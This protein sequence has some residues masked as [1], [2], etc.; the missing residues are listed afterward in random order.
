[1]RSEVKQNTGTDRWGN[2]SSAEYRLDSFDS[3]EELCD[4]THAEYGYGYNSSFYDDVNLDQAKKL[5]RDGWPE[6]LQ[7]LE[8]FRGKLENVVSHSIMRQEMFY[9]VTGLDWDIGAVMTGEPECWYDY[10]P[11]EES[12]IVRMAYNVTVSGGMG[13]EQ[14]QLRGA[15]IASLVDL[16]EANG[17]RVELDIYATLN[18]DNRAYYTFFVP[19]KQAGQQLDLDRLA[20]VFMHAGMSRKLMFSYAK[21][22][23]GGEAIGIGWGIAPD[24]TDYDLDISGGHI[25]LPEYSNV[26]SMITWLKARLTDFGVHMEGG[27]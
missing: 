5:A 12:R 3:L 24:L 27:N 10:S 20:F 25:G 6:G 7:K 9:D 1:M 18:Y 17:V 14:M 22:L 21:T 13:S 4:L 15:C 2:N 8:Q 19:I 16:L 26:S 23:Y 11:K